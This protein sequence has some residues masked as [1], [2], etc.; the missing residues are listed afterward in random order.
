MDSCGSIA[1]PAAKESDAERDQRGGDAACAAVLSPAAP[2]CVADREEEAAAR[3]PEPAVPVDG[4]SGPPAATLEAPASGAPASKTMQRAGPAARALPP[5]LG[6]RQ[7]AQAA[8][9]PVIGINRLCSSAQ[10]WSDS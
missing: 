5:R 8:A 2:A 10:P 7:R 9:G 6:L 4:A 3:P 1:K